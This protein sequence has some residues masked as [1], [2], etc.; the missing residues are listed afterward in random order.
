M[1]IT[2]KGKNALKFMI[3]LSLYQEQ[4]YVRLKD[5]AK[6]E[7]ISEKYL[8]Q[9]VSYLHKSR[10]IKS[11]RGANGGYRLI[12]LPEEYSV[13]EI[14]KCLE[15][16]LYPTDCAHG[17]DVC[18]HRDTCFCYPLWG[19]LNKA[20]DE[21]LENTSLQDLINWKKEEDGGMLY[22]QTNIFG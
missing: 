4:G 10:K 21:V 18:D 20:M 17:E 22:E 8:E 7:A 9:I 5:V 13:G 2:T 16:D 14:I 19:K 15:G 11:A 12:K 1:V 6:R 3:D